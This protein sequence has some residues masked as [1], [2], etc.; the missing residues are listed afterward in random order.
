MK[1][2]VP[3]FKIQ[4]APDLQSA[5]EILSKSPCKPMAGGTDLMV[6]FEAGK[7]PKGQY[8][9][10]LKI[11]E[12]KGIQATNEH[13]ELGALTTYSEVLENS[14]MQSEF[15][16]LC[17]AARLTGAVAIQNRGTLGGNIV[18]ASPAA[19]SPPVLLVY[20]T[21]IQLTSLKGSRWI[22]YE[23]FHKDYKKM[24][25]RPDELLTKIRIQ[26]NT[27]GAAEYYHKV[28]TRKAQSI[29]KVCM[30]GLAQANN[31]T[32]TKFRLAFGSVAATPLRCF[33][34]EKIIEGQ[35]LSKG[36]IDKAV[37]TLSIEVTPKDDIRS[38]TEYRLTVAQNLLKD[39]LG[40][41]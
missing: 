41:L 35:K 11:K 2:F 32:V 1:S 9:D 17:E 36:L 16:M 31:G 15:K 7:L 18:N 27:K 26:R 39:F 25:I 23:T 5:L 3:D 28:G 24:D 33:K 14:I 8:L 6:L 4:S 38:T 40:R 13:V 22:K 37:Q 30:A 12:L 29:S 19:D 34:T 10:I 20:D 21:E